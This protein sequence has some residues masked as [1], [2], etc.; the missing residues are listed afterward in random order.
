MEKLD[1]AQKTF[2]GADLEFLLALDEM[3]IKEVTE[4]R[5]KSGNG[6]L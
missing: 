5:E 6:R 1:S 2:N 3:E 4:S